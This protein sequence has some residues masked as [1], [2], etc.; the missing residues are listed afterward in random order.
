MVDLIS[1]LL[2]Y[3]PKQRL[4]PLE[5]LAHPVF[6]ELRKQNFQIQECK[7]P[8]LFNFTPGNEGVSLLIV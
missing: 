4:T 5:A 7:I 2:V 1:K 8:D 6:D 3:N